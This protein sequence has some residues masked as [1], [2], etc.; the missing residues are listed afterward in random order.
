MNTQ[1]KA[2]C[3]ESFIPSSAGQLFNAQGSGSQSGPAQIAQAH[4]T[5]V[6]KWAAGSS[7][8]RFALHRT[9][10]INADWPTA[11]SKNLMQV[12]LRYEDR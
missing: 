10:C 4:L 2:G 9:C 5:V 6:V 12:C 7:A 1:N 3:S 11:Y 8:V